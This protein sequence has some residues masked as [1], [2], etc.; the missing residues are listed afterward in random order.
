MYLKSINRLSDGPGNHNQGLIKLVSGTLLTF[1]LNLTAKLAGN[2]VL[3]E[4]MFSKTNPIIRE[5]NFFYLMQI[6]YLD[7]L[8]TK[9]VAFLNS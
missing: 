6:A 7:N 2:S 1:I 8:P 4:L 9:K 5:N 3:V